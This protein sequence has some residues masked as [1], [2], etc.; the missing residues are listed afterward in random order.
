MIWSARTPPRVASVA[1]FSCGRAAISFWAPKAMLE[2]DHPSYSSRR[3][4]LGIGDAVKSL[5]IR[6]LAPH[7]KGKCRLI[8]LWS[9]T[10]CQAYACRGKDRAP[11]IRQPRV[12]ISLLRDPEVLET[13]RD[14]RKATAEVACGCETL[15]PL[16]ASLPREWRAGPCDRSE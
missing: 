11:S 12:D 15:L 2:A 5:F 7:L 9:R 8:G 13:A 1:G 14:A 10:G 4:Y 16:C 6:D 3:K